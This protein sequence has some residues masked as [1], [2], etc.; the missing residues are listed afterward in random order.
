MGFETIEDV[1]DDWPG[2]LCLAGYVATFF[3]AL[4][5]D[6]L[7]SS[8]KTHCR[9]AFG[10]GLLV[11]V[12]SLG[13]Y[14]TPMLVGGPRDMMLSMLIAQQVDLLNWP[15]AACLSTML[16][17]LTLAMIAGFQR[18]PGVQTLLRNAAP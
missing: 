8:R 2:K 1:S 11:F 15:Y 13:F 6:Q 10:I 3:Y 4:V 5:S 7:T 18:L 14:I 12:L 17:A 9:A 16:L